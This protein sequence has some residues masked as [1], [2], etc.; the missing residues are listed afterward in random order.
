[1]VVS[2]QKWHADSD[3]YRNGFKLIKRIFI[4]KAVEISQNPSNLRPIM[5][6]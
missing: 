1:L 3:S 6:Y 5:E 2:N 4:N